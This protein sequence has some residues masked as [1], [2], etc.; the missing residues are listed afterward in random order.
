MHHL[1]RAVKTLSM[2]QYFNVGVA[3]DTPDGLIVP[4]IRDVDK[5]GLVDLSQRIRRNK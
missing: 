4:V 5:K 1:M 2:K 3:V